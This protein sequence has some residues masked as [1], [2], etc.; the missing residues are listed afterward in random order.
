[1]EP[2]GQLAM[3]GAEIDVDLQ[4]AV[5][6][7][8]GGVEPA[9][10]DAAGAERGALVGRHR[11]GA[12]DDADVD[13]RFENVDAAQR[14]PRAAEIVRAHG[15]TIVFTRTRRGAERLAKQLMSLGVDAAAIH[16][17]LSQ[18]KRDRALAGFKR[19]KVAALIATDVAARGIH[20]DDVACVVHFDPPVDA[21][22]YVHRSG[23]TARAGAT[24]VVV[25]FV[26]SDQRTAS[27][28][29]RAELGLGAPGGTTEATSRNGAAR[30]N[31]PPSRR[32]GREQGHRRRAAGRARPA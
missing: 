2:P 7:G 21:K 31:A 27:R 3:F 26:T 24:R 32:T 11:I 1:V 8:H 19:D 15:S 28:K 30:T 22:T 12:D 14:V 4:L 20:V 16:G 13:H 25:S 10:R 17:G 29:L 5:L 6:V 9:G 23:R 18:P